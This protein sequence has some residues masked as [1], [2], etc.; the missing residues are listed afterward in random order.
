[1]WEACMPTTMSRASPQSSY[2]ACSV[3]IYGVVMTNTSNPTTKKTTRDHRYGLVSAFATFSTAICSQYVFGVICLRQKGNQEIMKK[4]GL[5][6]CTLCAIT[7][8]PQLCFQLLEENEHGGVE[9]RLVHLVPKSTWPP[10][11]DRWQSMDEANQHCRGSYLGLFYGLATSK[12]DNFLGEVDVRGPLPCKLAGPG[13]N[14]WLIEVVRA[15]HIGEVSY[16]SQQPQHSWY[17]AGPRSRIVTPHALERHRKWVG[18][19]PW[20]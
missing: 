15:G 18:G 4:R 13:R 20:W 16:F 14:T 17:R 3:I 19:S 9:R 10:L 7:V 1:M 11:S 12:M 6:Y 8:F 5:T 2:M